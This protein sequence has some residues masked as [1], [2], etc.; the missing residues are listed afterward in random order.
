MRGA[1]GHAAD[2]RPTT[3]CSSVVII[4]TANQTHRTDVR[5]A[6]QVASRTNVIYTTALALLI[7]GGLGVVTEAST[8][9]GWY[10]GIVAFV[11]VLGLGIRRSVTRARAIRRPLPE[12]VE[13]WL[14]EVFPFYEWVD[15]KR[16]RRDIKIVLDEWIFEGIDGV[17]V[18]DEARAGVAAGAA[19]LLHGRPHWELP[20]RQTVLLY[21]ERFDLDYVVGDAGAFDGMAH[22]QGPVI[23]SAVAI[24]ESW[25]DPTDG[26]NVVLHELAHLLDYENAFADGV[27]S[28]VDPG[29]EVAWRALVKKEIRRVRIGRSMLRRYAAS[30]PAELFAVAVENFFERPEIMAEK[31]PELFAAMKSLFNLD[32][33]GAPRRP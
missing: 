29:S 20:P 18:T 30:N 16:F 25:A 27:P 23:L 5:G 4:R 19:L 21:P 17:A 28:L 8:P 1:F 32:P 9:F 6:M 31:H 33:Y 13:R 11:L 7:G 14:A 15:R 12:D 2:R 3:R 22:Q 26:S 24:N 10:A